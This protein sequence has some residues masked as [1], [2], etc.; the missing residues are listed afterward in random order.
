MQDS[1]VF[2]AL[3]DPVRRSLIQNLAAHSPRT[4][5]QLAAEYPISRQGIRKHLTVLQDAGLVSVEQAGRDKCYSL[6]PAPFGELEEWLA[7]IEILWD[8]RLLRLKNLLEAES[9]QE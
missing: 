1:P 7:E 8:Q 5:T 2:A 6:T 4:A 3:A 9:T